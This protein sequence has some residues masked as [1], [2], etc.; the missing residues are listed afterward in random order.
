MTYGGFTDIALIKGVETAVFRV[1]GAFGKRGGTG[2]Q[3]A[4]RR[5]FLPRAANIAIYAA[6]S[7]K[8][9]GLTTARERDA[10]ER[11]DFY[12]WQIRF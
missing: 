2:D 5:R 10:G 9:G 8:F 12:R 11:E 6:I 3:G 4:D 1:L 7:Q